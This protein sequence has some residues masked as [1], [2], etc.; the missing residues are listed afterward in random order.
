MNTWK[1]RYLT[2]LA[3]Q[4]ISLLTS[5]ILQMAIIFYLTAK[6]NSAMVLSAATFVGFIPQA[7]LG[8]FAGAFVDRHS[9]KKVMIGADLLIAAAGGLLAVVAV[10]I[11]PPIWII[12][13]VLFIRSI[14]NAYHTPASSAVT[15]LMVPQ[16]Q[17]TKCAGYTQTMSAVVSLISPAAAAALYSVW[18]L[19]YIIMLD[20]AGAVLACG[21]VA[22]LPIPNPP[23]Q[24]SERKARFLQDMNDGYRVL[25]ENKP[26]FALL[27]IG[28]A[29]MFFFMPIAALF[30]LMSMSYFNGTPVHASIAEIA[31]AGGMLAGGILLSIW[32][33]FKN[34]IL[35]IGLSIL[36]MGVSIAVSGLLPSSAFP[37]FAVCC[38]RAFLRNK[39]E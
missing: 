33:G 16:E 23:V 13:L 37:A 25:K 15:P 17:L 10:F 22:L 39:L 11:D 5:G 3:G 12:M 34:R 18:P 21:I 14:G 35:S 30:P 38:V 26:L 8:P 20:I 7:I 1:K 36:V 27:W 32:G 19:S 6:T 31:F 24:K 29:Y 28:T 2:I 4:G 9:R